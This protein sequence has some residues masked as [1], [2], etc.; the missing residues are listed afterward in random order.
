MTRNQ[1]LRDLEWV[2]HSPSLLSEGPTCFNAAGD[3]T[4]LNDVDPEHLADFIQQAPSYR[5]G[6]YFERLVLYWLQHVRRVEIV[7]QSQQIREGNITVGE[8]DLMFRDEQGRLTHWEVAVKFYL[9]YPHNTAIGSHF[10][11]PNAAD[12]FERKMDRLFLHQLPRSKK[13]FPDVEIREAFVKGQIF[14]H[15]NH[16]AMQQHPLPQRMSLG[17]TRGVWLRESE[18][19]WFNQI[20]S[21]SYRILR[22]PNWLT[23]DR[24]AKQHP[25]T[26]LI[27]VLKV[28]FAETK[29]PVLVSQE[30]KDGTETERIFVVSDEWPST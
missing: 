16:D 27:E 30:S 23:V 18:L 17:H 3:K 12:T 25:E 5:V 26:E 14:Y 1:Y 11:G 21:A 20:P 15:A 19:D 6:R 2:I 28:G 9:H 13:H 29:R 10:I 22:K 8:I 4:N 7:A 24:T